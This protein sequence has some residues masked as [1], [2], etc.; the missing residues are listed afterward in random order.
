Q[1]HPVHGE[2]ANSKWEFGAYSECDDSTWLYLYL[3]TKI[4]RGRVEKRICLLPGHHALYCKHTITGI[5]GPM[6]LGHHAM[7]K[8]P[9]EPG[10]G[11]ISTSPFV[12]G[13]TFY[14]PTERPE[15]RGYSI[16][17]PATAFE[18]LK[19]VPMITGETTDLTRYP[20]RRGFDDIVM[21]V[22]D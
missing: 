8:F 16:L 3:N 4:R 21:L 13:Q 19:S 22:A 10:S 2:V 15:S 14:E 7:I 11:V 20:V 12:Y 17:K 18:S 1:R 5:S 6:P 9:D